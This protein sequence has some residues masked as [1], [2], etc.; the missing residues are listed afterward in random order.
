MVKDK[1]EQILNL[2]ELYY[3]SLYKQAI[4]WWA[5]G[6]MSITVKLRDQ[7]IFE[8]NRMDNTIRHIRA[9]NRDEET[10]AK[11]IGYNLQK[12]IPLSG[13]TQSDIAK[14]LGITNAMLSRYIHGTSV[15]SVVKARRIAKAIGCRIDE[16]FD[17]TYLE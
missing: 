6:P 10:M 9:D 3:P 14:E 13:R 12:L 7:S 2:F 17:S 8:Y 11:E 15:P 4:D 5:S 16:L 1:Y